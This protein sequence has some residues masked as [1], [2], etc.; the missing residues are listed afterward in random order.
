MNKK[1][2]RGVSNVAILPKYDHNNILLVG[3]GLE[4]RETMVSH[5]F[6]TPRRTLVSFELLRETTK[7]SPYLNSNLEPH[8][9]HILYITQDQWT[10]SLSGSL[11]LFWK[12]TL[13]EFLYL[14]HI[15]HF[16]SFVLFGLGVGFQALLPRS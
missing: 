7:V 5:N 6:P 2:S 13:C 8:T 15:Q 16:D 11:M 3:F 1:G 4:C 12:F 9:Q 14:L 10:T